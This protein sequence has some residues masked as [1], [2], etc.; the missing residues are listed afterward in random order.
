[1]IR[2]EVALK[3][4]HHDS[5]T[6]EQKGTLSKSSLNA[7]QSYGAFFRSEVVYLQLENIG[8]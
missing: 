7:F 6:S 3:R 2:R 8:L 5:S 1:M 4:L